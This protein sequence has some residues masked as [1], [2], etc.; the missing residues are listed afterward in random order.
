MNV[1]DTPI[2]TAL[3]TKY[4]KGSIMVMIQ[5]KEIKQYIILKVYATI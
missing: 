3:Y 4:N 5:I 1:L 2:P